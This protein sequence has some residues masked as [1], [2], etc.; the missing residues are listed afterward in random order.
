MELTDIMPVEK[1]KQLVED[2]YTRFGFNS[3]VF[4][5]DNTA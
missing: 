2:I 1:W 3:T 4:N 5:I